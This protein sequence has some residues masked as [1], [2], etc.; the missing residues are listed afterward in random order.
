MQMKKWKR[1]RMNSK[2]PIHDLLRVLEWEMVGQVLIAGVW[3]LQKS[4][5]DRPFNDR[6][7]VT[8]CYLSHLDDLLMLKGEEGGKP[9]EWP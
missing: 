5:P 1:H 6:I 4:E 9:V 2:K 7:N 8:W 3:P